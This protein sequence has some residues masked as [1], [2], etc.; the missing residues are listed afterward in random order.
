MPDA[1]HW[2]RLIREA[3]SEFERLVEQNL[4]A[5]YDEVF[6]QLLELT[7]PATR[8]QFFSSLNWG[9]VVDPY[10]WAKYTDQ[11]L[12]LAEREQEKQA[13]LDR[14]ALDEAFLAQVQPYGLRGP[15][16]ESL[17]MD[18]PLPLGR[19]TSG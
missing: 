8:L 16:Q 6:P 3:V 14:R 5:I 12:G 10:L 17:G 11:A 9:D 2:P 4:H 13:L 18:V 15:A 7:P 1:A 19:F